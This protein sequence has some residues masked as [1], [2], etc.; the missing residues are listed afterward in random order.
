MS[1]KFSN[2]LIQLVTAQQNSN[3]ICKKLS[4]AFAC[5]KLSEKLTENPRNLPISVFAGAVVTSSRWSRRRISNHDAT[6]AFAVATSGSQTS[7]ESKPSIKTAS[8][9]SSKLSCNSSNRVDRINSTNP[10]TGLP[11]EFNTNRTRSEWA[12]VNTAA[13]MRVLNVLRHWVTKHPIVSLFFLTKKSKPS[14]F[15]KFLNFRF[16]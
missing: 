1:L 16:F 4:D 11:S 8:D 3:K 13:S 7:L 9:V 10:S 5:Q 15:L 14:N 12:I 6:R 2:Q